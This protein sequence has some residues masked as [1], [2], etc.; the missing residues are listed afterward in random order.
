MVMDAD[1]SGKTCYVDLGG[2]WAIPDDCQVRV[3]LLEPWPDGVDHQ[4]RH[5]LPEGRV[6]GRVVIQL[7]PRPRDPRDDWPDA[8]T[9]VVEA[10]VL[11]ARIEGG[12]WSWSQLPDL[13]EIRRAAIERVRR[14][15]GEGTADQDVDDLEARRRPAQ[16]RTTITPER[17][18]SVARAYRLA[19]EL[20]EPTAAY[21]AA[22]ATC[23]TSTAR[24][25]IH[26]ARHE[27]DPATG[28]PYLGPTERGKKGEA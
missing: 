19:L 13:A 18:R 7:R 24:K 11:G 16:R 12:L 1:E 10:E 17:L 4:G 21:V 28:A 20:G 5:P 2:G 9:N 15:H 8:D 14:P 25:L 6:V 22:S 27:A 3:A 23:A 26:M